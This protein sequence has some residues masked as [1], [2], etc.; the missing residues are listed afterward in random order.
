M[1]YKILFQSGVGRS[2][3]KLDN[4]VKKRIQKFIDGLA[5][6]DNPRTAGI[7]MQGDGRL[8]RYRVGDYRVIADIDDKIITITIIKIGHRGKVYR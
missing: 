5:E 2:F 7:A 3:D 4:A 1:A 8:W 6:L